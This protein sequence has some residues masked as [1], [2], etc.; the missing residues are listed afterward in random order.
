MMKSRQAQA[1]LQRVQRER[2][3]LAAENE[4]LRAQLATPAEAGVP[5]PASQMPALS[6]AGKENSAPLPAPPPKVR[7]RWDALPRGL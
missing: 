3:S 2:E 7:R 1:D 6:E 5:R 4:R